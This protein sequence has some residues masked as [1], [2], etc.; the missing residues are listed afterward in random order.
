MSTKEITFQIKA[1]FL[2]LKQKDGRVLPI[3]SISEEHVSLIESLTVMHAVC[4]DTDI[5][6]MREMQARGTTFK[7]VWEQTVMSRVAMILADI[8]GMQVE[9]ISVTEELLNE[10]KGGA[11]E[12]KQ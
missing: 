4:K 5:A 3:A 10:L 8:T 2:W 1:N 12:T 11:N 7:S 9:T 6:T